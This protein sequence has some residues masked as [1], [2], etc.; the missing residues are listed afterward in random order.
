MEGGYTYVQRWAVMPPSTANSVSAGYFTR[1]AR[2]PCGLSPVSV[3]A[4]KRRT[5]RPGRIGH[6]HGVDD[7]ARPMPCFHSGY[8]LT[9]SHTRSL[10]RSH[11][12]MVF[13]MHIKLL[14]TRI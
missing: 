3:A 10:A 12:H 4:S 6:V 13:L 11:V 7:A 9:H 1:R 14:T 2:V 5:D 8:T